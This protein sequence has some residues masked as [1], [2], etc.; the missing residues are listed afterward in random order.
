[1]FGNVNFT[2]SSLTDNTLKGSRST[3][4]SNTGDVSTKRVTNNFSCSDIQT[5]TV[6]QEVDERGD[7]VSD[8][9]DIARSRTV[10]CASN[11]A[12]IHDDNVVVSGIKV[13]WKRDQDVS[14]VFKFLRLIRSLI[15]LPSR[16]TTQA[17]EFWLE[18]HP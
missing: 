17:S 15:S 6:T 7:V 11:A 14:S 16:T 9:W 1:M 10:R 18:R 12:P 3:I 5:C 4:C 8:S 2:M 13:S